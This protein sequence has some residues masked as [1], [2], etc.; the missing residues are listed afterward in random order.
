MNANELI[1]ALL[2]RTDKNSD[3]TEYKTLALDFLQET[4]DDI[5]NRQEGFHWRFLEVLGTTF[6]TAE[7]DF[8][9]TLTTIAPNIDTTKF[10]HVYEKTNDITY[11]FLPYEIFRQFIADETNE[12]GTPRVCSI[13]AGE[14]LL[15]PVPSSI[16]ATYIDYIRTLTKPTEVDNETAL[17]V[18]DK[19]RT[20]VFNGILM[21]ALEYDPELGS[22]QDKEQEYERGIDRMK[23]DQAQI[24]AEDVVPISHRNKYMNHRTLDGKNSFFFPLAGTSV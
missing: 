23:K 16:V 5:S 22:K 20:V 24:I 1:L 4:L 15:W 6:N 17:L 14:L 3:D 21:R 7:D 19:Y 13:F 12:G 11:R 8:D 2:R 9:Y 18:P 10:I